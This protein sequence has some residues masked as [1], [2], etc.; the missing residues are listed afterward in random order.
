[1]VAAAEV[2]DPLVRLEEKKDDDNRGNFSGTGT[3]CLYICSGIC[4]HKTVSLVSTYL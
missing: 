3:N 2:D 1:M 4:A